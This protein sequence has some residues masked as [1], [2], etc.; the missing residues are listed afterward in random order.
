MLQSIRKIRAIPEVA[1][2]VLISAGVV[3]SFFLLL[4][5]NHIHPIVVYFLQ[6]YLA[7]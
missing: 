3:L 7:F 1:A 6:L 5:Q 2:Q 4:V